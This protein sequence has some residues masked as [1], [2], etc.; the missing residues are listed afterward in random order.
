MNW[1]REIAEQNL[2]QNKA[3]VESFLMITRMR[4]ETNRPHHRLLPSRRERPGR[5]RASEQ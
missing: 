3:A 2:N 4:Q 1:M 5:R